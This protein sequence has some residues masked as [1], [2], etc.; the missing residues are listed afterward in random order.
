MAKKSTTFEI[1]EPKRLKPR[2]K[3]LQ[4]ILAFATAYHAEMLDGK[5]LQFILN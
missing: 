5:L 1:E 4:T 2:E 3:T